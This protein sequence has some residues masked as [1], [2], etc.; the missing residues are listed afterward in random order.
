MKDLI[1]LLDKLRLTGIKTHLLEIEEHPVDSV[2][3]NQLLTP[4]RVKL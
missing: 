1:P 4:L 2:K 3:C